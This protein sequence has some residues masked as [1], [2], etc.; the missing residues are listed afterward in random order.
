[1]KKEIE[2]AIKSLKEISE[3][4]TVPKNVRNACKLAIESLNSDE[5]FA[6]RV[7]SAL[8]F[9]D[10]IADDQNMPIYARTKI[11]NIVS[12]LERY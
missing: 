4:L 12:I 6:I 10:L 5:E 3:D 2:E 7:N 11:W 9:L 8:S 1:M